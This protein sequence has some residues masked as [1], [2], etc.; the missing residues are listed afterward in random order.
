[1][2]QIEFKEI[3]VPIVIFIKDVSIG[4]IAGLITHKI[5][6]FFEK[7]KS[8]DGKPITIENSNVK[9]VQ[10]DSKQEIENKVNIIFNLK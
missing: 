7:E 8:T 3:C 4:V 10:G 1:M 9:I 6:K 5:L 2:S